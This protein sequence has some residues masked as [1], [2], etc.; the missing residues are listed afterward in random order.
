M[1]EQTKA[2]IVERLRKWLPCCDPTREDHELFVA[3]IDEI[4]RLRAERPGWAEAIE[5]A[6]KVADKQSAFWRTLHAAPYAGNA[7]KGHR[8]G[9]ADTIAAQIR[10]LL[11]SVAASGE[12]ERDDP[13][14]LGCDDAEFGMKP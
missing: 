14:N 12:P 10:A 9:E 5:A 11:P 13:D 6:A 2:D 4:T 3:A 1:S 7:E 8:A